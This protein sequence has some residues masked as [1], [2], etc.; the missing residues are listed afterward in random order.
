MRLLSSP[1]LSPP[2]NERR[3]LKLHLMELINKVYEFG[4]QRGVL[5]GIEMCKKEIEDKL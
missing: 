5:P 1:P 3:A 4:H 2:L